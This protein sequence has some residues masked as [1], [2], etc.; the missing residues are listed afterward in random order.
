[1]PRPTSA[2]PTPLRAHIRRR[3]QA[4]GLSVAQLA[5]RLDKSR[6]FLSLIENGDRD[7]GEDLVKEIA[8][9]LD[10]SA[11]VYVELL[12]EE[13]ARRGSSDLEE[14]VLKPLARSELRLPD[15]APRALNV[16]VQVAKPSAVAQHHGRLPQERAGFPPVPIVEEGTRLGLTPRGDAVDYINIDPS[17]LP[18][19]ERVV[20]PF[21]WKLSVAGAEHASDILA[22][23][24]TVIISQAPGEIVEDEIYAVRGRDEGLVLS[25]VQVKGDVLLLMRPDGTVHDALPTRKGSLDSLVIGKVVIV[26]R[27]WRYTVLTPQS[28]R[29]DASS[30]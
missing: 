29:K 22:P 27:P 25:R 28:K 14:S 1:M 21:A 3:R 11:D 8:R 17:V 10:D 12:Q 26:I 2:T 16:Q 15:E 23:G 30:A 5:S 13:S 7:V 9:A 18:D 6:S 20:K 24:D 4:R 19:G